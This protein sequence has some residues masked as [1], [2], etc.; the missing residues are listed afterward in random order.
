MN[1]VRD[2]VEPELIFEDLTAE[3][4]LDLETIPTDGYSAGMGQEMV[5]SE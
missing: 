4:A 1:L 2:D 5:A 3:P